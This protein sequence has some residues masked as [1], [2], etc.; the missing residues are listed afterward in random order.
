VDTDKSGAI[1]TEELGQLVESV[2][3]RKFR[4]GGNQLEFEL[5]YTIV[6]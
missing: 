4:P 6:V 3:E 5:Q 1:S 2:G